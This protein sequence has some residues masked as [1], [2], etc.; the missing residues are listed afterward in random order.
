MVNSQ[1]VCFSFGLF[2][3]VN[4]TVSEMEPVCKPMKLGRFRFSERSRRTLVRGAACAGPAVGE[5]L[6]GGAHARTSVADSERV[7]LGWAEEASVA[8]W[9]RSPQPQHRKAVN[10]CIHFGEDP[11]KTTYGRKR[12]L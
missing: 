5:G 6:L 4:A 11:K 1:R 2:A 3:E 9:I 12:A 7:P 10:R 8:R